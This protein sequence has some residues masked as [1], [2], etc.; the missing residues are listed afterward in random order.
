MVV[1]EIEYGFNIN[2]NYGKVEAEIYKII[3]VGNTKG[4]QIRLLNKEFGSLFRTPNEKDYKKAR[5][6]VDLQMKCIMESN[7]YI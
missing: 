1:K 4:I 2:P 5:E 3:D 6:W 7:S